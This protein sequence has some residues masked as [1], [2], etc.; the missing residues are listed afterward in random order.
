ASTGSESR[1]DPRPPKLS[2]PIPRALENR[3][4]LQNSPWR[5]EAELG[6][7]PLLAPTYSRKV[8]M[9]NGER[10]NVVVFREH[11]TPA[12][13]TAGDLRAAGNP[14]NLSSTSRSTACP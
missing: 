1:R 5:S 11:A 6:G 13:K 2:L 9:R 7:M 4:A 12:S 3:R 8:I 10:G 14:C